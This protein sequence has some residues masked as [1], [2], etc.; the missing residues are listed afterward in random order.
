LDDYIFCLFMCI[1]Y[2]DL[3]VCDYSVLAT[4]IYYAMKCTNARSSEGSHQ[5]IYL[6]I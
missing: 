4:M 2:C 5:D 1:G 3:T 6:C